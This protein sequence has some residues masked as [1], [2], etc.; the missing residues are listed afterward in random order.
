MDAVKSFP[1]YN[2]GKTAATIVKIAKKNIIG[3]NPFFVQTHQKWRIC[4]KHEKPS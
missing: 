3:H 1:L 2:N 4:M